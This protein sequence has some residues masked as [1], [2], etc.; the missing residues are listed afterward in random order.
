MSKAYEELTFADDFMFCKILSTN[1]DLTKELLELLL[2][3]RI[4]K[5]GFSAAQKS[6]EITADGRGIRLDVYVE[7]EEGTVFD[8]EMQASPEHYVGLRTR[9]YQGMIDL[10]LIERGAPFA[11]LKKTYVIFI[12]LNDPFSA[13]LPVYTFETRCEQKSDLKLGD[14]S[15]KVIVNA[16]GNR[17]GLPDKMSSFLDYLKKG[18][19]KD[20]FTQKLEAAVET[21]RRHEEWR[22]EYMTLL[23]RDQMMKEE[24]RKEGRAEGENLLGN[25][26]AK[27]LNAGRTDDV[28]KAATDVQARKA[29]FAEFGIR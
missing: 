3:I 15:V 21:A 28:Q 1:I 19:A 22:V 14:E 27:L 7:D 13:N 10:D 12:L 23:M 5:I 4:R 8:I 25:L 20:S 26:I 17:E 16:D 9:Y 18:L 24:G 2:G 6:I 29:L 11:D